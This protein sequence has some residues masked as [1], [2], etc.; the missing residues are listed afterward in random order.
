MTHS[1]LTNQIK[2]ALI[3]RTK[4][5]ATIDTF[6]IHHQAGTNDDAVIKGMQGTSGVSSNYTISNEGRLTLVVNEDYRAWTSGS[7]KDGG[8]GAA[9][10]HRSITVEIENESGAPD[11]RISQAA[12]D[13]AA[14]L[15]N[16]LKQRYNIVN[17]LGHRDLWNN[18]KASYATY[19]PGPDTVQRIVTRAAELAN[20]GA[21]EAMKDRVRK[22]GTYL[23]TLGLASFNTAAANDGIAIDPGEKYSRYYHLVQMWGAKHR[24]DIYDTK[25]HSIDGIVGP[26]TKAVEQIIENMIDDGTAPGLPAKPT[27]EPTPEPTPDAKLQSF[28][29]REKRGEEVIEYQLHSRYLEIGQ[30]LGALPP[31]PVKSEGWLDEDGN[32]VDA[33][34]PV[35]RAERYY[36]EII[37]DPEPT[38]VIPVVAEPVT[39]EQEQK[40]IDAANAVLTGRVPSADIVIARIRTLVPIV[41]GPALAWLATTVPS[42]TEWLTSN[43][44][45]WKEL[46]LAGI[47]AAL[48][49]GYWQLAMWLG[50]RWPLAEKILL[51]S[52]KRPV[53]VEAV[54]GK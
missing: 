49:F 26:T 17:V 51:G 53:Y 29:I 54:D 22:I 16:D 15:L 24:P 2:E 39:A 38:P 10:D 8:K 42:V 34:S 21:V 23:N 25:K 44:S 11:W 5:K 14:M 52:S 41:V 18:Y 4:R 33:E 6:L 12:I 13:K 37:L 20:P 32:L 47:S 48:S 9:W 46:V 35:R 50:K 1:P 3:Q 19:C 36:V 30:R 43:F 28:W 40:A 45:D 31:V 27:P 7:S